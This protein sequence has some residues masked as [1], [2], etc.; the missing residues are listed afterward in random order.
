[1]TPPQPSPFLPS[2]QPLKMASKKGRIRFSQ[3]EIQDQLAQLHLFSS[4]SSSAASDIELGPIILNIHRSRQQDACAWRYD[5][6]QYSTDNGQ[7]IS[8][9]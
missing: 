6:R 1:M 8:Q 7:Q 5:W 9:P 3:E 2:P 4:L